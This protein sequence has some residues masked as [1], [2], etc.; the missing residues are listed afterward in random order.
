VHR[1]YDHVIGYLLCQQRGKLVALCHVATCIAIP[2]KTNHLAKDR[3]AAHSWM[4]HN[5]R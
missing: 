4:T 1:P 3:M 2:S 5:H